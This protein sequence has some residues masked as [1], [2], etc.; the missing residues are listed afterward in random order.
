MFAKLKTLLFVTVNMLVFSTQVSADSLNLAIF[1]TLANN[2]QIKAE[3]NRKDS[4]Q[5][6]LRQAESGQ[7]P[8][9]D[10]IAA[11]GDE[12]ST[13]R[14]T[15]AAGY[16]DYVK[17]TRREEAFVVTYNLFKGFETTSN[18][19]KYTAKVRAANHQLHELTEQ[20]ALQVAKAY[21][22]VLNNKQLVRLSENTL[23]EHN[24]LFKK[25][26]S[27]SVSGVGRKSDI[28]QAMGRVAR[29]KANLIKDQINLQNAEAMYFK[30]TGEI[31]NN[32]TQPENLSDKLPTDIK[33]AVE[34]A[35]ASNPLINA[36]NAEIDSANAARKQ[37]TSANYPHFDLVFEQSRGENLD[38][39]EG[40]EN[41]Y[42]LML[43]MRYNIFNGGYDSSR[44]SQASLQLNESKDKLDNARR[45]ITES[46][47]L[48]WNAYDSVKMQM[49][50][51]SQ[52]VKSITQTRSSYS[53]Q[54]RI[55]KRSL[56][57]LLDSENELYQANRA[58]IS[59][60]HDQIFGVY[61]ILATM[62]IFVDQFEA[63]IN[64]N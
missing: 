41:D 60:K 51:L 11:V 59:A 35:L 38:G 27:R 42:S 25:V 2:P 4:R 43:K 53:N 36:A 37:A 56:L 49:P 33:N 3:I 22:R 14:F 28:N 26:K 1:K 12:N 20:T 30:L 18:I 7:Y 13:N 39:I 8:K 24:Q 6:E 46:M 31:P 44:S 50:Y 64:K 32:L 61:K 52:H 9:V 19:N 29:A 62:G 17:L 58:L 57:D 54:V 40:V 63:G 10:L 15:K 47:R 55:G 34:L 21:L 48:A 23:T 16:N 45:N 5:E